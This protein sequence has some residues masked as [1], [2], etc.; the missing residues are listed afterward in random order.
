ME[1]VAA[2]PVEAKAVEAKPAEEP[3]PVTEAPAMPARLTPMQSGRVWKAG[4]VSPALEADYQRKKEEL[5][6]RHHSEIEHPK[7]GESTTERDARHE[8]EQRD[9]D[10]AFEK[11]KAAGATSIPN[12]A[13]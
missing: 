9:L 10:A 12:G 4:Q 2:K 6:Q 1:P 5:D 11:A 8:Q 7:E 13:P 3:K